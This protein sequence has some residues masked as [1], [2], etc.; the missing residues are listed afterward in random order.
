MPVAASYFNRALAFRP[1]NT[2]LLSEVAG[3]A[4]RQR[5][6]RLVARSAT[7][8]LATST[9]L[10]LGGYGFIRWQQYEPERAPSQVVAPPKKPSTTNLRESPTQARTTLPKE[11]VVASARKAQRP[12]RLRRPAPVPDETRMV[13]ILIVGPQN[14]AVRID[15]QLRQWYQPQKLSVGPHTFEFLAPKSECCDQ[16]PPE[17]VM[18]EAG[19]GPQTVRGSVPFKSAT[20]RLDAPAGAKAS[21]GVAGEVLAGSRERRR[22]R[23]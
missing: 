23:R 7:Y 4:R 1:D 16:R 14:A 12:P 9:A 5:F 20:L 11:L 10:A 2:E 8:V 22:S 17:T 6:R 3:M 15:G 18:I 13:K 19:E 21:C